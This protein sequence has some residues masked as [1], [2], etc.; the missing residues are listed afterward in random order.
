MSFNAAFAMGGGPSGAMRFAGP[1]RG[2]SDGSVTNG[3]RYP[4]PFF[5]VAHSHLPT[6]VK[7]LFHYCRYYYFTNP[8][9]NATVC[10]L[11][12][13][14]ITDVII[15]HGN[16]AT[17]DRWL[18]Y[19]NDHLHIRS[20]Q[21]E[22]GLDYH[23]YGNAFISLYFPFHK[24]LTCRS[25]KY[26]ERADRLRDNWTF[27][28]FEFRLAC[29]KCGNT[30]DADV[31]DHYVRDASGIRLMRWNPEDMEISYN[32]TNGNCT[33]YYNLPPALR[34]DI[35]IGK[36]DVVDSC[37]QIFIQAL[38][39]GKGIILNKENL[40]HLKRP[41][42]AWQDRGWGI[43]LIMP[44]LKDTFYLQLMK[45]AQEAILLEH[46]VPLRVLFPQA[47]S[48]SSDPFTTVN[49][50]D[51]KEQVAM[52]IARWRHDNNYI[53]VMPIPLGQQSI[54]GDGRALLL[55]NEM[56]ALGEDIIMG[57]GVPREFLKGGLSYAGT[58]VSMRMLENAFI[59]YIGRQEALVRWIVKMISGYMRWPEVGI[60]FKPF[61]MADDLQR[62]MYL[63]QLNQGKVGVSNTTLLNDADLDPDVE[64][65]LIDSELNRRLEALRKEQVGLAEMQGEANVIMMKMQAKAQ[66]A[67]M[68]AQT[69]G[70]APGEAGGPEVLQ[71]VQSPL[72]LNDRMSADG[73][74]PPAQQGQQQQPKQMPMNII[75]MAKGYAQQLT[76][77]PPDQQQTTLS[78]LMQTQPELGQLVQKF[79]SMLSAGQQTPQASTSIDMRP[80]PNKLPPR[81][82]SAMV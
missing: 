82:M 74:L 54:G 73:Y 64:A 18:E 70:A 26:S 56:Q 31:H 48:G 22:S 52:E 36:K 65:N 34:N 35:I 60:R 17:R 50:T 24:Y 13:Y 55:F 79:L 63:F 45:K 46:I 68:Q 75:E 20:F 5:D 78:A 2:R 44:V 12:E 11:S 47:A 72:S 23:C 37:P 32:E 15:E 59:G 29:P 10:K 40:F 43:P 67:L 51:W 3:V 69:T 71:G 76:N 6:T 21:V 27:S 1:T 9:I 28:N 16:K 41:T 14:P 42:L 33:Y 4:S 58:N 8:L 77:L 61:K 53:P 57:M 7:R 81:R 25:C 19:M 80:M 39:Q 62:K 49:L 30:G 38:R 66:E